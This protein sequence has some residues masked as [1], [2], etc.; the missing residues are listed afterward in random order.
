MNLV[1]IVIPVYN[2]KK[3]V[4]DAVMS[5]QQQSYKNIEII[6][7][8]DGAT[9]GSSAILD[10]IAS[11]DERVHVI[12]KKN[13]G[14]CS[15]RNAGL[16]YASG[17]L[18]MFCDDDDIYE[19]NAIETMV[20]CLNDKKVDLV[21][22]RIRY[23]TVDGELILREDV[24]G[25]NKSYVVDNITN[26]N[27]DEYIYIRENKSFVYIWNGI[28]KKDIINKNNIRFN[29]LYKFGGEDFDFNYQY[30]ANAKSAYFLS[31]ELYTH[32]KRTKHSTSA[33]YDDNQIKSVY[34]NYEQEMKALNKNKDKRIKLYVL[35]RHF[36][37]LMSVMENVNCSYGL[38]K[39]REIYKQFYDELIMC[40][41]DNTAFNYA[42][43]CNSG[44]NIKRRIIMCLLKYHQFTLVAAISLCYRRKKIWMR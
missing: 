29:S 12:H 9:D 17:N 10:E 8:D 44:L 25:V 39:I 36:W 2:S 4:K 41:I 7:V 15:A 26:I 5:I 27:L 14:I 43:L 28:F 35:T 32:Y 1:S 30:L 42:D 24:H 22:F 37:G 34:L 19:L 18:I 13:G 33:K 11:E 21:K 31:E 20:T 23:I 40:A 16:E 3:Y 38:R 6:L